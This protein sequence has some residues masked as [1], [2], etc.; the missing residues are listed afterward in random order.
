MLP[1]LKKEH[2]WLSDVSTVPLQQSL[3]H[4][5][6]AFKN[7]FEGRSQVSHFKKKQNAQAATYAANAFKWENG[8]LTLAKMQE[9]LDIPFHRDLSKGCKP[10]SVTISKDCA[11]RYFV[12][13]LV[14]EDIKP[15]QW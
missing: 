12:S 11:N 6:T 10:S 4:L 7:F 5:D 3:R 8:H 15:F 2:P 14:E 13:M 9:P 1:D